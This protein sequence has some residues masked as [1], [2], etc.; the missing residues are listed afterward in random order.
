VT[1][2]IAYENYL[3]VRDEVMRMKAA[4]A[5]AGGEGSPSQYWTEELTNIDYMIEASPLIIR[6][7]RHH[8]FHI[9]NLRPYEYRAYGDRQAYFERRMRALAA[10][11]GGTDLLVPEAEA[12]GGFGYSID[13]RLYNADTLKFFE[14]L[15]GMRRAGLVDAFRGDPDRRLVWEIGG[16]WGGFAYQFKTLFP[17]TTYVIV[18]FPEL[19]LFSATYLSTVFPQATMRFWRGDRP[20]FENWQEADFIFIPADRAGAMR[21]AEPDLLVNL[22]SFQEMT[23]AQVGAYASLA[24]TTGCPAL[25][26]LNRD[27]SHYNDELD[28]VGHILSQHYDLREIRLLGSD[29]TK[30]IKKDSALTLEEAA[31]RTGPAPER[32]RHL[33]GTLRTA[34]ALPAGRAFTARQNETPLVG[35]GVT[36]HNRATYL[37]EALDSLLAQSYP[38]FKLVLVDDGSTDGTEAIARAYARRDSRVSYVRFDERRG[39]IAAWRAAFEGATS[40]GAAYFA[41]ASDHDR[42][43]SAWLATLVRELEGNPE[44]VLAYPLTERMDASGVPLPKAA[45]QFETAGVRDLATRWRLFTRSDAVAAGD[46]VYGIMRADAARRAGIFR[47]VLCP[48]RLLMAELTLQGQIRQVPEVLWFRRQFSTGSL[49]RQRSSLFAP[50][51]PQPGAL[52]PPWYMHAR[53]LWRTYGGGD[54]I[55]GVRRAAIARLVATYSASYAARH[56]FKTQHDVISVVN[57]PRWLYKRARHAVLLG[58]YKG[59][60]V[61]RRAGI[62][63]LIERTCE[64]LTG[65]SRPWRKTA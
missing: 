21:E 50:D 61:A 59:L 52:T 53:A 40:E 9:T 36:M 54:V 23:S 64:R 42:W 63:P 10:L 55:P 14:V 7:L 28:S 39:M 62:T 15:V 12:L 43:H 13:G 20:V 8:A 49:A 19:F 46:M 51:G 24:A 29:Y 45:R 17:R 27:K 57:L 31:A 22:V 41:W 47:E 48:D 5:G 58:V 38:H 35:I 33:V 30:A 2:Q 11:G 65:R 16:G 37:C 34:R 4:A 60:L 32:Y 6:K 26:S 44:V 25:Y 56:Y 1:E 18:D 3:R